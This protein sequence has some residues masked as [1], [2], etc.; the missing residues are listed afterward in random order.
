MKCNV[1]NSEVPEFVPRLRSDGTFSA[2][3]PICQSY[4]R[5]RALIKGFKQLWED[6]DVRVFHVGP[7]APVVTYFKKIEDANPNFSYFP[8]DV[9]PRMNGVHQLDI[10]KDDHVVAPVDVIICLHVLEHCKFDYKAIEGIASALKVGGNLILEVPLKKGV[11]DRGETDEELAELEKDKSKAKKPKTRTDG[12]F[13]REVVGTILPEGDRIKRFK[14]HNH[15]RYYGE[16]DIFDFLQSVGLDGTFV[17]VDPDEQIGLA[18]P[19][20][21]IV[22]FQSE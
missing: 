15:Y 12:K 10:Q 6:K 22:G 20:R 7:Y 4:Q 5:H 21:F 18:E 1:C 9:R 17:E 13:E 2:D 16:D 11:T 19:Y 3:C 8:A 14:E